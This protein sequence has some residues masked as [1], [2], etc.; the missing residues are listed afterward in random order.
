MTAAIEDLAITYHQLEKLTGFDIDRMF[1]GRMIR[2]SALRSPSRLL[3]LL[4]SE[5]LL[6]LVAFT[7]CLGAGLVLMRQWAAAHHLGVLAG[8]AGS[9]TLLGATAWYGYQW[10]RAVPRRS[11][12]RL[13]D[14]VDHHND[15][16]Q[17]LRIQSELAA[18]STAEGTSNIQ[19]Q[20]IAA[21][22][23]TRD[24]LLAAIMIE[25]V[26]RRHQPFMQRQQDLFHSIE[27]NLAQLEALQ[28]NAQATEY[29]QLL[30]SALE[31]GLAVRREL[32]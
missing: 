30:Q 3:A 16:V 31:I 19:L 22:T 26:W 12:F 10:R 17:A 21:L 2:P 11:L 23:A 27:T 25:R 6:W 4:I 24:A 32:L 1:V 13:L 15:M 9:M 18:I 29:Q 14:E 28:V 20:G 7:L 5:S 8:V